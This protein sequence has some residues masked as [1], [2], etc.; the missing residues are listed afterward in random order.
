MS[1]SQRLS[2]TEQ[3]PFCR[4][5][6]AANRSHQR[7]VELLDALCKISRDTAFESDTLQ[8]NH[9]RLLQ[10]AILAIGAM[11]ADARTRLAGEPLSE[12]PNGVL[13]SMEYELIAMDLRNVTYPAQALYEKL[14]NIHR[15]VEA[16]NAGLVQ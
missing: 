15:Q 3:Q 14:D 8:P 5:V 12:V 16:L 1:V 11:L 4:S 2:T 9:K 10:R 7:F 6:T 13:C